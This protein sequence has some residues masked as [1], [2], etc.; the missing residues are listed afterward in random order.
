[1]NLEGWEGMRVMRVRRGEIFCIGMYFFRKEPIIPS[2]IVVI[3]NLIFFSS[4][5]TING[6]RI[7]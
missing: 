4:S 1:V 5:P 7:A 2:V 3:V 6:I